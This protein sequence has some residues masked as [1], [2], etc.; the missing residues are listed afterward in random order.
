MPRSRTPYEIVEWVDRH[1]RSVRRAY[2]LLAS[3]GLRRDQALTVLQQAIEMAHHDFDSR[4]D[5]REKAI[6]KGSETAD[7]VAG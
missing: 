7:V 1:L 2:D 6:K 4:A 3:F 5:S